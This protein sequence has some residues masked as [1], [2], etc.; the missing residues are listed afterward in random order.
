MVRRVFVGAVFL[1]GC[2]AVWGFDRPEFAALESTD[3]GDAGDARADAA[4]VPDASSTP[5]ADA[6]IGIEHW[7]VKANGGA[8]L[9][10]RDCNH[11]RPLCDGCS[12][13][14]FDPS[15]THAIATRDQA[16]E[17]QKHYFVIDLAAPDA[18]APSSTWTAQ[19]VALFDDGRI[20]AN[21]NPTSECGKTELAFAVDGGL[22][23]IVSG[24]AGAGATFVVASDRFALPVIASCSFVEAEAVF[25]AFDGGLLGKGREHDN[26]TSA[27]FGL[28]ADGGGFVVQVMNGPVPAG[29]LPPPPSS[30]RATSWSGAEQPIPGYENLGADISGTFGCLHARRLGSAGELYCEG[31]LGLNRLTLSGATPVQVDCKIA[32]QPAHLADVHAP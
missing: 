23:P 1:A 10:D 11:P 26:P 8:Y 19:S 3:A 9:T 24:L 25:F 4:N 20:L 22:T 30:L 7:L 5:D 14:G 13:V 12:A 2:S 16:T 32:G 18:S 15:G 27:T 31:T 21:S 28:F 17:P 6:A 29:G